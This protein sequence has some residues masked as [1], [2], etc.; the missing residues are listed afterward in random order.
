[1]VQQ[2]ILVGTVANDGTGESIRDALIKA[3][4]HFTELYA[5]DGTL[6][7]LIA[8]KADAGHTHP[9]EPANVNIQGHVTSP[10]APSNAQLNADITKAEIEAKLTGA[11][12][13]HSH[14]GGADPWTTIR[15][16]SDFTTTSSSAVD[17]TGLAFT[18]AANTHY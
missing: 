17:V 7:A 3:N 5:A 1:M 8:Q 2:V 16:A 12:T 9:Y 4:L 11:I 10:H 13:S 14:A 18:P 6:A 15:L